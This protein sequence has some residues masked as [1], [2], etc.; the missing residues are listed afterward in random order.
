[1]TNPDD[2]RCCFCACNEPRPA[3]KACQV[4]LVKELSTGKFERWQNAT[5][6]LPICS[7]CKA[8]QKLPSAAMY[9][10]GVMLIGGIVA[11][12]WWREAGAMIG[13]AGLLLLLLCA[14]FQAFGA[15]A[16]S[17]RGVKGINHVDHPMLKDLRA[18]G[19]KFEPFKSWIK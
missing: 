9:L 18:K 11:G 15:D 5:V 7:E 12:F 2:P 16:K 13:V 4:N 17:Y 8:I 3:T 19:F 1:M 14:L 10:A 6:V